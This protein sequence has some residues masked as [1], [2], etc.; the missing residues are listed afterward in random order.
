MKALATLSDPSTVPAH[1]MK[2]KMADGAQSFACL[3]VP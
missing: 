3:S 2:D 1:L